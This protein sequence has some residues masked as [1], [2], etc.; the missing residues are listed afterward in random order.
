MN[1]H[2]ALILLALL[3]LVTAA[4]SAQQTVLKYDIFAGYTFLDSPKVSLFEPGFHIQVGMK[5][6]KWYAL[7]FDYSRASGDLTLTPDLLTPTLQQ[8]LSGML[9]QL[10]AMGLVP[11]GYKLVVPSGSTTQ[12]FAAGPQL[13]LRQL[14]KVT[15]FIRPSIGAI[16]ETATPRGTDA[17]SQ[18]IVKQ[19]APSGEK[20]DWVA[21]YGFG[22]GVDLIASKHFALR[23]QADF[24]RDHLFS[25]T[26]ADSRNT[27]R[28]SIGPA[29]QF[30]KP[31]E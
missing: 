26:L 3:L 24:V 7:G 5:P 20:S 23:I 15:F 27:V 13:T 22:G 8:Q 4:A 28:F 10:E 2:R 30:G 31:V 19:L 21:F 16:Q 9:K 29:F 12:T 6:K 25:D 11:P 17:I 18:A 1:L 14:S